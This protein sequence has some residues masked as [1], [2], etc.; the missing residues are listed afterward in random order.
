M[1]K[2]LFNLL[3]DSR[4]KTIVH[5]CPS[6]DLNARTTIDRWLRSISAE[7][8]RKHANEI[9]LIAIIPRPQHPLTHHRSSQ[10]KPK[11]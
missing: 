2:Q 10:Q 5:E 6:N 4:N 8:R 3:N 1:N 7:V 9:T 11:K